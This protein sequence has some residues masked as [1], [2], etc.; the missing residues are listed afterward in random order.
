MVIYD[1]REYSG[2]YMRISIVMGV[3]KKWMVYIYIYKRK[4][5]LDDLNG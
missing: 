5:Y 1:Y 2:D 4:F 3:P